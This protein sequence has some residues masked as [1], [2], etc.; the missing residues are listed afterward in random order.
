MIVIFVISEFALVKE[1]SDRS[2]SCAE[3]LLGR[4]IKG[5]PGFAW[6]PV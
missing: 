3:D 5:R 2:R 4:I 1:R 6:T